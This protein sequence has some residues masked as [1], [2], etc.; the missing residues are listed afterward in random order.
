MPSQLFSSIWV[1][2]G[3][4]QPGC[5]PSWSRDL[6]SRLEPLLLRSTTTWTNP[7]WFGWELL[8]LL[9]C[10]LLRIASWT[11]RFSPW[12]HCRLPHIQ[13]FFNTGHE[14]SPPALAMVNACYLSASDM[15]LLPGVP[16]SSELPCSL[17]Y[18][19]G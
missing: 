6:I 19:D 16:C 9:V 12:P 11:L 14:E 8:M 4:R 3:S 18:S 13:N 10:T 2:R 15:E 1:I 7:C 5:G 17:S